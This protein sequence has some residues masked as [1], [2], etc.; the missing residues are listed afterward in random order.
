MKSNKYPKKI[1]FAWFLILRDL[2][3]CI[4]AKSCQTLCNPMDCSLP[5]S[6]VHGI[7]QARTGVGC[8]F[9]LQGIF[10]SQGSKLGLLHWQVILYHLSHQGSP[11][12]LQS[13]SE[14]ISYF[15]SSLIAQ[16]LRLHTS[17]AGGTGLIAGWG[18]KIPRTVWS[19]THVCAH[20]QNTSF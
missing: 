16:W 4:V 5:G 13:S 12:L 2:L 7:S 18:T 1:I 10:L 14:I 8:H 17:T 19:G 11:E 20:T 6:S 9:L 3:H 15:G